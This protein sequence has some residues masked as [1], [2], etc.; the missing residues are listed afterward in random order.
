[1][2][3][4]GVKRKGMIVVNTT[5]IYLKILKTNQNVADQATPLVKNGLLIQ[6]GDITHLNVEE[7]IAFLQEE[8][9][10]VIG[11]VHHLIRQLKNQILIVKHQNQ[12]IGKV[13]QL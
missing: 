10:L 9:V 6:D 3:V 8:G 4:S 11:L 7:D 2:N 1:M 5:V 12:D 13:I